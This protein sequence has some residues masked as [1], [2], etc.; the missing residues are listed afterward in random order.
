[1]VNDLTL[2]VSNLFSPEMALNT[3]LAVLS[4]GRFTNLMFFKV[5]SRIG[6]T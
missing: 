6:F 3:L 2:V 1:M 5:R 4:L